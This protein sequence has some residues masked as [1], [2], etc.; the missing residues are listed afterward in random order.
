MPWIPLTLEL[1]LL[2]LLRLLAG[3]CDYNMQL[4]EAVA[5]DYNMQL[6]MMLLLLLAD[7]L[8]YRLQ[9]LDHTK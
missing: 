3:A 2:L 1:L 6:P 8:R 4:A 9:N 7:V 5:C